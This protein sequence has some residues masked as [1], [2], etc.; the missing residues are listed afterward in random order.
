MPAGSAQ[1]RPAGGAA[2]RQQQSDR[3]VSDVS[4]LAGEGSSLDTAPEAAL[5]SEDD[6]LYG[7]QNVLYR[8]DNWFPWSIRVDNGAAYTSNAGLT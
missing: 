1:E 4:R 2:A 3:R 6:A 5:S 7:V 8:R